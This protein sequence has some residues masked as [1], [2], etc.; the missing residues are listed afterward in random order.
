MQSVDVVLLNDVMDG[1]RVEGVNLMMSLVEDVRRYLVNSNEER[2]KIMMSHTGADKRGYVM[3]L[4]DVL[5]RE[6]QIKNCFVF[7]DEVSLEPGDASVERMLCALATC[8]MGH[9]TLSREYL[10]NTWPLLELWMLGA[11]WELE[12]GWKKKRKEGD[13]D[14]D[15][16]D[17]VGANVSD[18]GDRGRL[19]IDLYEG[20]NAANVSGQWVNELKQWQYLLPWNKNNAPTM[21]RH[22]VGVGLEGSDVGRA[23]C[24]IGPLLK[25]YSN[26]I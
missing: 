11:R 25:K 19:I 6:F 20:P 24:V 15:C 2:T 5:A 4:F 3:T 12:E 14:D 17:D 18:S 21:V 16:D 7:L 10:K 13:G 22:H 8:D 9:V 23:R 26:S 1:I